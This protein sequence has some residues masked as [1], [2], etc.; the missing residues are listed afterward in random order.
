[1]ISY[2]GCRWICCM[3][4][5]YF[6]AILPS[7]SPNIE[8]TISR[9]DLEYLKNKYS[10][11]TINYFYETVF[12]EDHIGKRDRLT[13]WNS[14]AFIAIVGNPS[15]EEIG[16]VERAISEINGLNLPIRYSLSDAVDSAAVKIIFGD[17]N[18]VNSF[19][20]VDSIVGGRNP[21]AHFGMGKSYA[22]DGVIEKDTI[23]IY[24]AGNL[25]LHTRYMIVLEEIVQSLGVVGD[26]YNYPGS[27]FFQNQNP[28]KS[29]T[30]LDIEVLS[31]LYETV[32]PANY[33]REQFE[34]DFADE[35][36]TVNSQ[37]KIKQLFE[38]Y[39]TS[40]Y[41]DAGKCFIGDILLKQPKE[42]LLYVY[43][44]PREEDS[45]T[46][47]RTVSALNQLSPNVRIIIA[48]SP[49]IEPDHGIVLVIQESEDQKAPIQ[50]GNL[51]AMGTD[52]MLQKLIQA[53]V[54]LSISTSERAQ[55]LR[56]RSIIDAIYFSLIR[57]PHEP[58]LP[59]ELFKV[60]GGGI[61][62]TPR[63]ASLL[64]LIYSNEFIDG[65]KLSDYRKLK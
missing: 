45:L 59:N 52:C 38:T 12:H 30:A 43:G 49:V 17:L 6:L 1:M 51:I 14:N 26:S 10:V 13:K 5:I 57:M 36:Y 8:S 20:E 16:Y 3:L 27:L 31:L 37:E 56:Q 25:P 53:K 50:V 4:G 63:Y 34:K 64:Q 28:A 33:S 35:L 46:I 11:E 61:E 62:F 41:E 60:T 23:G 42:V 44:S 24:F 54:E 2:K 19:L 9:D 55:E 32:V 58:T 18:Q 15:E 65:L 29:L 47:R 40:T 39:P 22:S 48:E 21:E 7:C